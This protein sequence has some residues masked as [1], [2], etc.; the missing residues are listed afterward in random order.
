MAGES[1]ARSSLLYGPI[2]RELFMHLRIAHIARVTVRL[3]CVIVFSYAISFG[4]MSALGVDK[5][6]EADAMSVAEATARIEQKLLEKTEVEYI[7][8]QLGDVVNDLML[9]H[10][11]DIELDF[12]ALLAAGKGPDTPITKMLKDVRLDNTLELL[13]GD[14]DLTWY[15][16]D[17][18]LT[19]TTPKALRAISVTEVYSVAGLADDVQAAAG[20]DSGGGGEPDYDAIERVVDRN[21]FR[22]AGSHVDRTIRPHRATKT[23]VVTANPRDQEEVAWVIAE[24]HAASRYDGESRVLP[25]PTEAETK[26]EK[27][28]GGTIEMQYLDT[29]LADV[30]TDLELRYKIHIELD[31]EGIKNAG[32]GVN[33]G[34]GAWITHMC[35]FVGFGAA[36]DSALKPLGLTWTRDR[37]WIVITSK[38]LEPKYQ[39]RRIYRVG[40]L[41]KSAE[42]YKELE[43]LIR[44]TIAVDSWRNDQA[45]A[46]PGP[47]PAAGPVRIGYGEIAPFRPAG[48]LV[49]TQTS[50]NHGAI[51][52]LLDDLRRQKTTEVGEGGAGSPIAK[53]KENGRKAD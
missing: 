41:A 3:G 11:F 7:D 6:Q 53:P 20:K 38:A 34:T 50:R 26:I 31:P 45:A 40:D 18:A 21:V 32:E 2:L 48:A 12:A 5:P 1:A 37:A 43:A 27:V 15:V 10:K 23:L 9:R 36:L 30:R 51:E 19:I 14:H 16:H 44:D 46:G 25:L 29:A 13:L 42:E 52:K 4:T 22:T 39:S 49:V 28:T 47:G 24:L 8:T 35:K 17:G 33:R